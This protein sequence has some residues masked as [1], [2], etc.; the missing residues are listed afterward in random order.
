MRDIG[1]PE[2]VMGN[3]MLNMNEYLVSYLLKLMKSNQII[4]HCRH[5]ITS[6]PPSSPL[7]HCTSRLEL[8]QQPHSRPSPQ[9]PSRQDPGQQSKQH[10][11]IFPLLWIWTPTNRPAITAS[12]PTTT[13]FSPRGYTNTPRWP[14]MFD[15]QNNDFRLL[16]QLRK[17]ASY[18]SCSIFSSTIDILYEHDKGLL[19]HHLQ[20]FWLSQMSLL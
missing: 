9:W 14:K 6:I 16:L 18:K 3:V 10:S 2:K 1:S 13:S 12:K 19:C 17:Q 8:P 15:T 11:L 20:N 4:I 7:V 5:L